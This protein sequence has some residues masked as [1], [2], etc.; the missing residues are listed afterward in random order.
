MRAQIAALT[1]STLVVGFVAASVSGSRAL[2][3]IVLVLGGAA[4]ARL[5]MRQAGA[6]RTVVTLMGVVGLF[7]LSHILG[8]VIGAWPAVL[9]VAAIAGWLAFTLARDP[10]PDTASRT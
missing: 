4:C 6:A 10:V 5:M 2:G 1:A 3:G 7:V 8:H 9:L